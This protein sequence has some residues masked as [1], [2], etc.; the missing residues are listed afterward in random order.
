MKPAAP[1]TMPIS[2]IKVGKRIRRDMGDIAGLAAS[3]AAI[4]LIHPITVDENGGLL[5]TRICSRATST[6]SDGTATATRRH[7][8]PW[9]WVLHALPRMAMRL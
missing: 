7:R 3:I 1:N 8:T 9:W 6:T 5:A 4:G 2:K